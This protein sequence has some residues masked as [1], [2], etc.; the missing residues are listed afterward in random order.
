M[1]SHVITNMDI[2][3]GAKTDKGQERSNN[4][5]SGVI[6]VLPDW[7]HAEGLNQDTIRTF[8]MDAKPVRDAGLFFM[9]ADGVGGEQ[10]GELASGKAV[11]VTPQLY[12]QFAQQRPTEDPQSWLRS[13]L[14]NANMEVYH[15]AEKLA[16]P[17][18]MGTTA[19][20]GVLNI[21]KKVVLIGWVGDSRAY[22][23]SNGGQ[24]RQ[25]SQ[26]HT[27]VEERVRL[28][29]LSRR[30]ADNHPR[31]NVLSRSLGGTPD[32]EPEFVEGRVER[33]YYIVLCS[34]GL[35]R[36][37]NEQDIADHCLNTPSVQH[38][39][40]AMVAKANRDGGK[41]NITVIVIR[42]GEDPRPATGNY[43]AVALPTV[44]P[45]GSNRPPTQGMPVFTSA[46][47]AK[48][49][50][51]WGRLSG[52]ALWG[53]VGLIVVVIAGVIIAGVILPALNPGGLNNEVTPTV[54]TNTN[55]LVVDSATGTAFQRETAIAQVISLQTSTS[56]VDPLRLSITETRAV[57]GQTQTA[58][59]V[60]GQ[61]QMALATSGVA[62]L[63]PLPTATATLSAAEVDA[64]LTA[65]FA[66]IPSVTPSIIIPNNTNADGEDTTNATG[67]QGTIPYPI[68][69]I[70]YTTE[71]TGL[72]ESAGSPP[73]YRIPAGTR[74]EVKN[75]RERRSNYVFTNTLYYHVEPPR[76]LY[77][78]GWVQAST[79]TLVA[80]TQGATGGN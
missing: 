61:T 63:T 42:I 33:D 19:V 7:K 5:D 62:T 10:Y 60:V 79:L 6:T 17:G 74:V 32:T 76:N 4:E 12:Y 36:Y 37:L 80:P 44:Q 66:A 23:V 40:E 48:R 21:E 52:R 45:K 59:A 35:S 3:V 78:Q 57:V 11:E 68:G 26:D 25:V 43:P 8:R 77:P 39:A 16:T 29:A 54:D 72:A 64:T 49:K 13:A 9:V 38:A 65:T 69:T 1:S 41:D 56:T 58:Q 70:L 18:R 15:L 55:Q 75:N 67:A 20:C 2:E 24:V 73:N 53:A 14:L 22:I 34:D 46:P 47:E 31:K 30:E 50:S 28:G 51:G 27:E 71:E